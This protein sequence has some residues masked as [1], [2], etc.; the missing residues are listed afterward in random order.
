MPARR[1]A[2]SR[3]GRDDFLRIAARSGLTLRD[4]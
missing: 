3:G 1:R 2:S 4:G